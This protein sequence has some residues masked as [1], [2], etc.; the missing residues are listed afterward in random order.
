[1][2]CLEAV[3]GVLGRYFG[4]AGLPGPGWT[5]LTGFVSRPGPLWASL[6]RLPEARRAAVLGGLGR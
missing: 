3:L 4:E 1:M 2:G 5:G 6:G